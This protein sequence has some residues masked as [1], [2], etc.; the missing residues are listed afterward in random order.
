MRVIANP[1]LF[2]NFSEKI[3]LEC[4]SKEKE[5]IAMSHHQRFSD[6]IH[7]NVLIKNGGWK[8]IVVIKITMYENAVLISQLYDVE[9]AV[10]DQLVFAYRVV[11]IGETGNQTLKCLTNN[12]TIAGALYC[13][14]K[15]STVP[16]VPL[17]IDNIKLQMRTSCGTIVEKNCWCDSS[18]M[19]TAMVWVWKATRKG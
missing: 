14:N 19:L 3:N 16:K 8:A 4:I 7:V 6:D 12:S 17:T 13:N 15:E 5:T 9:D 2:H 1:I 10:V 11:F 18:Y